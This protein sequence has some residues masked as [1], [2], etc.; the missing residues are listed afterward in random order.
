MTHRSI[1]SR[2]TGHNTSA[3]QLKL[4]A[5]WTSA[6]RPDVSRDVTIHTGSCCVVR[7]T[8][9][10]YYKNLFHHNSY[11]HCGEEGTVSLIH[12]LMTKVKK[13]RFNFLKKLWCCVRGSI[14]K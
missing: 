10:L 1:L 7:Q 5:N 13:K 11:S 3:N 14:T 9:I 8:M 2:R 4:R 6:K 12:Q